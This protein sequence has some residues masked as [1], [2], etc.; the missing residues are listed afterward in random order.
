MF[1]QAELQ[2]I[3]QTIPWFLELSESQLEG[4]ANIASVQHLLE[5]EALFHEGDP[6]GNT[7]ILLDGE[8]G[9]D[10][11]IP[12]RDKVRIFTAEPLDIVGWSSLTPMVRQRTATAVAL[13]DCNY[14]ELDSNNLSQMCEEDPSLG[15]IIM[16]RIS[17]VVASRLLTT[18]I[19]LMEQ[20]LHNPE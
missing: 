4:L 5:G 9:L 1:R 15:F 6:E 17:N 16:K 2:Q 14:L 3:L 7:Y 11:Q 13:V 20:L 18:R 8:L 10:I 12:G 19:Q